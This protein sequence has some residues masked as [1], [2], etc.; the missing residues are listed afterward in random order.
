MTIRTLHT[1]ISSC[2]FIIVIKRLSNIMFSDKSP[3]A[4][5]KLIDFG[6]SK[7]FL[8]FHFSPRF[9]HQTNTRIVWWEL[10]TILHLK[11]MQ[12]SSE[13]EDIRSHVICGLSELFP[14]FY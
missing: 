4:E 13:G 10:E 1:A 5:L 6:L 12:M 9:S 3:D 7:V 8:S 14:I 11:Y 2:V